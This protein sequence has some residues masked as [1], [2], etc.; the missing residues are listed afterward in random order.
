MNWRTKY[1]PPKKITTKNEGPI[2][3]QLRVNPDL[4]LD[5]KLILEIPE[6]NKTFFDFDRYTQIASEKKSLL[7]LH[8]NRIMNKADMLQ[9]SVE[10]SL[11]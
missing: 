2:Y 4:P 10:R 7:N 1:A 9:P 3:G 5:S 11:I 8:L 6:S